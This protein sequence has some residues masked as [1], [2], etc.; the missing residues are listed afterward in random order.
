MLLSL[1]LALE[2]PEA[3]ATLEL[4][5]LH[6]CELLFLVEQNRQLETVVGHLRVFW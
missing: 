5:R 6:I 3:D 2:P 1:D 4:E